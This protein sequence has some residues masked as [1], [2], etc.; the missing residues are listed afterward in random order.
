MTIWGV[1]VHDAEIP[2]YMKLAGLT[3]PIHKGLVR[4]YYTMEDRSGTVLRDQAGNGNR[5]ALAGEPAFVP[6]SDEHLSVDY[7]VELGAH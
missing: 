7:E 2:E 3:W 6:V 1:R 5:G 4:A